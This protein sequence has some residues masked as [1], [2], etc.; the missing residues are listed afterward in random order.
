MRLGHTS[1]H[2]GEV[3]EM[4]KVSTL[5]ITFFFQEVEASN[6]NLSDGIS[7]PTAATCRQWC[8]SSLH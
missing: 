1:L 2:M 7:T 6:N 8:W 5:L 3:D 4:T